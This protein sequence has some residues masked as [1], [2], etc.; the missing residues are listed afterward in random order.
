MKRFYPEMAFEQPYLNYTS[1]VMPDSAS[2][3]QP[4]P[5]DARILARSTTVTDDFSPYRRAWRAFQE[6]F[7]H[8]LL[9]IGIIVCNTLIQFSFHWIM[10]SDSPRFFGVFPLAWLFEAADLMIFIGMQYLGVRAALAR[11]R[12]E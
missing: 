1:D 4:S 5:A 8:T 10:R 12:G 6:W 3:V 9:I 11:Y 7:A 2:P